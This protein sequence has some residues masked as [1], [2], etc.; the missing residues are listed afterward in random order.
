VND[1]PLLSLR[2]PGQ[3]QPKCVWLSIKV[4]GDSFRHHKM[5]FPC[6]PRDH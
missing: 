1:L 4:V 2:A 3:A 6:L 5:F